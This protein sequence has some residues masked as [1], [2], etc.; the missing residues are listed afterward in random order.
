LFFL[1]RRRLHFH[2]QWR[3]QADVAV[4]VHGGGD[5]RV[6]AIEEVAEGEGLVGGSSCM[7]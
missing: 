3:R 4:V 7:M 5:E 1:R 2:P 6:V